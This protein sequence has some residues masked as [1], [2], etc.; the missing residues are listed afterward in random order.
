MDRP[1]DQLS[2]EHRAL[3]AFLARVHRE[4]GAKTLESVAAEMH[5]K[6]KSRISCLLRGQNNTL[7]ANEDQLV[8]LVRALGGGDDEVVRALPLYR[9]AK[10]SRVASSAAARA[11]DRADRAPR[12]FIHTGATFVGRQPER[13]RIRHLIADLAMGRGAAVMVEGEPGIGKSHLARAAVAA[14]EAA[15]C[16]TL[17][18]TC[19]E[20]SQE[21][22]LLPLL[23]T[24]ADA[25]IASE[26]HRVTPDGLRAEFVMGNGVDLVA[27]ATER[28]L[29]RIGAVCAGYPTM[30]VVDDLQWAD[31]VTVVALGRLAKRAPRL[32]LL[33]LCLARPVPPRDDLDA[34]R[35]IFGDAGGLPLGS[36]AENEVAELVGAVAGAVPSP[37]LLRLAADAGGNPLYLIELIDTLR[38][39]EALTI[40][41]DVADV[42]DNAAPGSLVAAITSRL[43]YLSPTTN[44]AIRLAAFLGT[45][46][47]LSELAVVSRRSA[48]DLLPAIDEAMSAG[49]IRDRG[50]TLTFR[51]P[52]IRATL[53]H[54]A[55][56]TVRAA[57]HRDAARSLAADGAPVEKVARQILPTLTEHGRRAD[58][59]V[60]DWL[61]ASGQQLAGCAPDAAVRLLRWALADTPVGVA[62]YPV[63][64][65]RL[66]DALYRVGETDEAADLASGALAGVAEPELLVDLLWTLSLCEGRRRYPTHSLEMLER[67]LSSPEIKPR[68]RGRLLVLVARIRR[69][70]G[71][72]DAAAEAVTEAHGV[73]T[74]VG[75]RWTLA[76]A[77]G[78]QSLI[79]GMRGR[80]LDLLALSARAAA[81]AENDPTLADLHLTLLVNQAAA[82][83]ELDRHDEAIR[84]ARQAKRLATDS[85][86]VVRLTHAQSVIGELFFNT[87]RWDDALRELDTDLA[88]KDP[89][90]ACCDLARVALIRLHRADTVA[91]Q[92]LM[93][94]TTCSAPLGDRAIAPLVLARSLERE[95]RGV[96]T[97]ALTL[98]KDGLSSSEIEVDDLLADTVRLAAAAGN[99][100]LAATAVQR[101][102]QIAG[103]SAVPHRTAVALH[104]RGLYDRNPSALLEASEQY[105][106]AG[107]PLPRAQALE[108]AATRLAER[109]ERTSARLHLTNAISIYE[110]LAADYDVRRA[111]DIAISH[112]LKIPTPRR[113]RAGG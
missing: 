52:L 103:A 26:G 23:D 105:R 17:W 41:N 2:D 6:S 19:D 69:A 50:S 58:R 53:Y 98:L 102:E 97:E 18:S 93:D 63:L 22:P 16:R 94:A 78:V 36:L 49:V 34:L 104:C 51:H 91:R 7:P 92:N 87:G 113:P 44:E 73:A 47:S 8:A 100:A 24:L 31:P 15:G 72:L 30:V 59:W 83:G 21:F 85:H 112:K 5:L 75:D 14:A 43:H 77:L 79:A 33:V 107:R 57:W 86:N 10:T 62:A 54:Q 38:R 37:R 88:V 27:A 32:P 4:N 1:A 67:A 13:D 35:R 64:V 55:P 95:Q 106:A 71:Q 28:V 29:T 46:F 111:R 70:L 20:L 25:G 48:N 61:V 109:G 89:P 66:A 65:C 108:A 12:T 42:D 82:L 96:L 45:D 99:D 74:S 68:Q 60:V 9:K 84:T 11:L 81:I 76:W 90:A 80:E 110:Q 56:A 3:L 39:R 101:A 40:S